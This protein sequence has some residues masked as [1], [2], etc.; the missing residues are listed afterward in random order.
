MVQERREPQMFERRDVWN[1]SEEDPWHPIIEWYA[2]A[3][4]AMQGR[5]GR[6][7]ADPASW[8][9]LAAIHGV[10]REELPRRHWPRGATWNECQHNSWFFLPWH[11]IYLHYFERIVRQT[12]SDLGGPGDWALPYWDYSDPERENVRR[13]PPAFR[14]PQMPSGDPNPLFVSER[15]PDINQGG[16]LNPVFVD[17]GDAMAMTYFSRPTGDL[18]PDPGNEFL[19]SGFGGPKTGWNHGQGALGRLEISPHGGVHVGFGG[20]A[21]LGWMSQ[22]HTAAR[23]PIFWLHHANIDRL[24][25][26]WLG[27]SDDR[28]NPT[29]ARWRSTWYK[30]GGGAYSV[31]L[32]VR[33]V[34]DTTRPPLTYRYSNISVPAP[35][36][37]PVLAA[38]SETESGFAEEPVPQDR[39]PEMVGASEN[40]VPLAATPSE[41]EVAVEAPS[42]PA[43]R[44]TA[45]GAQ[46]RR[47]YLKVENVRGKEIA[48]PTYLVYVNLPPGADPATYE[49]RRVG[50]VTMFGVLEASEADEEHSGSGL[51]YSF[52]IT[53]V[54]ERLKQAGKWDP[55]RLRVTFIPVGAA[56]AG[57]VSAG[58]VSLFYV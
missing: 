27:Q 48:A 39:F 57:D 24:W 7:F 33:E 11:R 42:G 56:Q 20:T 43:L 36:R 49:D 17:T 26:A 47:V 58:R 52:E 18:D 53:P 25:E 45:E 3:I 13:L 4:T 14:E 54:V 16:Q 55:Q 10:D 15:A 32:S 34:L 5:D 50:Q 44:E 38:G 31:T 23:D 1:L 29:G 21:P 37:A 12:I 9:Y 19:F 40:R 8:R 51:T 2:R 35:A 41:V 30:V 6:D 22:F 46:P 28:K